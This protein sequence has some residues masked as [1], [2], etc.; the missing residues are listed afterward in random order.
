MTLDELYQEMQAALESSIDAAAT[1]RLTTESDR[2]AKT[3]SWADG[4]IDKDG[5]ILEAFDELRRVAFRRF[6]QTQD[7]NIAALHDALARFIFAVS[8][9]DEDLAPSPDNDDSDHDI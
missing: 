8:A 2:Y 5:R 7:R 9:H 1:D 6:E 3:V 4:V